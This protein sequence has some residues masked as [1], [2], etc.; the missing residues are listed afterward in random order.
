[1]AMRTIA[2]AIKVRGRFNW[3]TIR[4]EAKSALDGGN[5]S[6]RQFLSSSNSAEEEGQRPCRFFRR[7]EL[8]MRRNSGGISWRISASGLGS[9]R[10][11][12]ESNAP[13]DEPR[14]ALLPVSISYKTE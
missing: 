8:T 13:A 10:I 11:T 14:K 1:M 12:A 6:S 3:W 4:L 2:R 7:H 9:S 5:N